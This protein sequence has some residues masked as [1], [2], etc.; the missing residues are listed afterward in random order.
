M[1]IFRSR[2]VTPGTKPVQPLAETRWAILVM[3]PCKTL[4]GNDRSF[5]V[6]MTQRWRYA[7]V[8]WLLSSAGYSV[9]TAASGEEGLELFKQ[10]AV[11]L[12]IAEPL[13]SPIRTE[14]KLPAR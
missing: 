3:R 2:W 11:D 7:S 12:V 6:S 4:Q 1:R 13:L 9:L 8:S 5:C 14:R 10:N